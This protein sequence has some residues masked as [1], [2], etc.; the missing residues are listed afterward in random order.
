MGLFKNRQRTEEEL[1]AMRTEM[2]SL[3]EHLR[4]SDAVK[5]RLAEQLGNLNA[6]NERLNQQVGTVEARVGEVATKIGSVEHE[7]VTVAGSI[8]PAVELAIK[9]AVDGSPSTDDVEG[10]RNEVRSLGA[11]TKKLD[12]LDAVVAQQASATAAESQLEDAAHDVPLV[13]LRK[14][15]DDLAA[16]L[17]RQQGQIADVAIVATDA[18]ERSE[19][20]DAK[21][22]GLAA[23]DDWAPLDDRSP[24]DEAEAKRQLGQLAEKV[25]GLDSRVNQVSLELTNQLTELSTDLDRAGDQ[26]DSTELIDR[27]NAQLDEI[28]GGQERL[29]NEQARYAIQFR[30]DL[31]DLAE[32]LK[33]K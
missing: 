11:L 13:D 22:A 16:A 17:Q 12:A 21:V 18:A 29:A 31:A 8:G 10:L 32:R 15:L 33:R 19:Q 5:S 9:T 2:R 20:T 25:A 1:E 28:T 27:I 7:V 24:T 26:T 4:Q 30:S 23:L 14:Q 6:E 3:R